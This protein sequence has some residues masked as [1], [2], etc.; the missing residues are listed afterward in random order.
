MTNNRTPDGHGTN[1]SLDAKKAD[2]I[3]KYCIKCKKC[4]SQLL[5]FGR[6]YIAIYD[7][8]P[9]YGKDREVCVDCE[10]S[11]EP[12]ENVTVEI[13]NIGDEKW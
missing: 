13:I 7:D 2:K 10:T 1:Y 3:I 5:S 9:S 6:N 11:V 4:W 8:F 12:T